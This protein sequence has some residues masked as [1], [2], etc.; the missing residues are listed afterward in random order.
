MVAGAS[1]YLTPN[2]VFYRV[3]TALLV[4]SVTA[5]EWRLR[6][7]GMVDRE[8]DL[9]YDDLLSMPLIERDVTLACV[10]NEVGGDSSG[11]RGGS[12]SASATC[13]TWRACIPTPINS[14]RGRR[15]GGPAGRRPRS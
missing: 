2:D 7:H 13:S 12:V 15:T 10:S 14:S 8:V 4:P 5:E 9:T 6:V 11:T 1:T 3:D